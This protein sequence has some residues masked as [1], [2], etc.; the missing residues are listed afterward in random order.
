VRAALKGSREDQAFANERLAEAQRD[1]GHARRD[2]AKARR[3]IEKSVR[4]HSGS[5]NTMVVF[6][7]KEIR[8]GSK[9]NIG[10]EHKIFVDNKPAS[11]TGNL[12]LADVEG[13]TR[14]SAQAVVFLE[15]KG[16]VKLARNGK[17]LYVYA[18]TKG[19]TPKYISNAYFQS[20]SKALTSANVAER[21]AERAE[22]DAARAEAVAEAQASRAEAAAEAK[23]A[24]TEALAEAM[25]ARTEA[26]ASLEDASATLREQ[27]SS[28]Q[29]NLRNSGLAKTRIEE[30]LKSIDQSLTN[31]E[32][33]RSAL[34]RDMQIMKESCCSKR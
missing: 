4:G 16:I 8:C 33:Q 31:V 25:A 2:A 21:A 6:D 12:T 15:N 11:C 27:R 10:K 5:L 14:H 7:Q 32:Q 23:A 13:K 34:R 19:T 30:I 29:Q 17:D 20:A 18:D 9:I 28:L 3:D 26:L 24:R 22:Q 1:Y